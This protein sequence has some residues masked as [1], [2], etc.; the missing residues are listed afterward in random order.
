MA[1][2]PALK[3]LGDF[4]KPVL[5]I[6]VGDKVYRVPAMSAQNSAHVLETTSAAMADGNVDPSK[7]QI[8]TEDDVDSY[9]QRILGPVYREMMDSDEPMAAIQ[10]AV[11]IVSLW[12]YSGFDAAEAYFASGGKVLPGQKVPQ[13]RK[14]KTATRIRTAAAPTTRKPASRNGTST[15]KATTSKPP[16][17]TKS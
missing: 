17:E 16:A 1:T 10:H 5:A 7:L 13:D 11:R 15:P 4:M 14:P 8:E 2:K 6:P 3:E 9:M 12:T